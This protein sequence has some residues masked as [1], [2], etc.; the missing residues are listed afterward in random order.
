MS[1]LISLLFRTA[2]IYIQR[3]DRNKERAGNEKWGSRQAIERESMWDVPN[4][5]NVDVRGEAGQR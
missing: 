4:V 5:L 2:N 3:I 1:S